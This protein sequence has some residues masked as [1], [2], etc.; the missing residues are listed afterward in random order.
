MN[1]AFGGNNMMGNSAFGGGS[2]SNTMGNSAAFGV[3]NA[4]MNAFGGGATSNVPGGSTTNSGDAFGLFGNN[5][6][7]TNNANNATNT[8][9]DPFAGATT[10]AAA[11]GNPFPNSTA[12]STPAANSDPFGSGASPFAAVLNKSTASGPAQGA[13]AGATSGFALAPPSGAAEDRRRKRRSGEI[14]GRVLP[15]NPDEP[16]ANPPPA[17]TGSMSGA[18]S[19][20]PTEDRYSALRNL[21][22]DGGATNSNSAPT[23]GL[24]FGLSAATGSS[25]S[26]VASTDNLMGAGNPFGPL[27]TGSSAVA[28]VTVATTTT[29][30]TTNGGGSGFVDLLGGGVAKTGT[31]TATTGANPFPMLTTTPAS[32]P[33]ATVSSASSIDPLAV[34]NPFGPGPDSTSSVNS[35]FPPIPG[36]S[37]SGASGGG[38]GSRRSSVGSFF[39]GDDDGDD[40]GDNN[41]SS[42]VTATPLPA[43]ASTHTPAAGDPFSLHAAA[44]TAPDAFTAA[45]DAAQE[46]GR[47]TGSGARDAFGKYGVSRQDLKTIWNLASGIPQSFFFLIFLF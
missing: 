17:R 5:N 10:A 18:G 11:S 26:T 3:G 8:F 38:S 21:G 16:P 6:N 19:T 23:L 20:A 27:P 7:A 14:P 30:T 12:A 2:G 9:V 47:V 42:R 41:G 46:G 36:G 39:G 22:G 43:A 24:G 40:D 25:T 35:L 31:S 45:W 28:P 29:A 33:P 32:A 1:N 13:S 37:G 34:D 44:G 15:P 4:N